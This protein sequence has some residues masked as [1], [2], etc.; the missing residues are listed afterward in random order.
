[1]PLQ[2]IIRHSD[3][4]LLVSRQHGS[5]QL[6]AG[7]DRPDVLSDVL[8]G[9]RRWVEAIVYQAGR[10]PVTRHIPS[11]A[12]IAAAGSPGQPIEIDGPKIVQAVSLTRRV[13]FGGSDHVRAARSESAAEHISQFQGVCGEDI[14]ILVEIAVSGGDGDVR[15]TD[16]PAEGAIMRSL[17]FVD[18][19]F[20]NP[21]LTGALLLFM[22]RAFYPS[23]RA[24][25]R[26]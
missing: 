24:S 17:W 26:G 9:R 5:L 1:M 16:K 4:D 10:R 21:T 23:S 19:N 12:D 2:K 25:Y 8:R 7:V 3:F 11:M 14:G 22:F 15:V 13:V 18:S 6:L 20:A